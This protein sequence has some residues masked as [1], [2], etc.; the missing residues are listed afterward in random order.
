MEG[1]TGAGAVTSALDSSTLAEAEQG[2]KDFQRATV[3]Y[4]FRRLYTDDDWTRR[5][6]IADEVGL[7]KTLVARGVIARAV[8]RLWG[9]VDPINVVYVC[10]NRNIARQNVDRLNVTGEQGFDL[11]SR[12]TLL[13][14]EV[15]NLRTRSL[16]FVAL[17]PNTSFNLRSSMGK[18]EERALLY[19]L[20]DRAWGLDGAP[21]F[22]VLQGNVQD[23]REFRDYVR[24][25]PNK[26]DIDPALAG[27]F[28]KRLEA[29]EKTAR[30]EGKASLREEFRAVCERFP[31]AR[32]DP[33]RTPDEDRRDQREIIG[34]L[35]EELAATCVDALEPSLVVLDEFQRFKDLLTGD[36]EESFLAQKLFDYSRETD[37]RVL[38]LSATP[39]KMYTLSGSAGDH[40]HYEDFFETLR[41]L[42]DDEVESRQTAGLLKTYRRE[43][44]RLDEDSL[45]E[46]RRVKSAIEGTLRRVMVRTERLSSSQDRDGMLKEAE[47]GE[48]E[49]Q[50]SDVETYLA[51]QD[52]AEIFDHRDTVRYWKSAPYLL[53]FME[54]YKLK[55]AF[56]AALGSDET[57]EDLVEVISRRNGLVLPWDTVREYGEIESANPRLRS[58]A[59]D[60]LGSGAW[61]LLWLAPSLPYY[62]P[63]QPFSEERRRSFTKRL[64]FSAWR[65]VPKAIATLLSYGA[66]RRVVRSWEPDAKNTQERRRRH[67]RP[68]QFTKSEGRLRGMPVL[69]MLYPSTV[70][71]RTCDPLEIAQ[72]LT[73][74]TQG[75]PQTDEVKP[76]GG[77]I[78][79]E[80][81]SRIKTLLDPLLEVAP[82]EGASDESWYWAAPPLI[83]QLEN[84]GSTA[85]WWGRSSL[86][87]DWVEAEGDVESSGWAEHV[88]AAREMLHGQGTGLGP[89]PDDLADVLAHLGVAGPSVVALRALGRI[90]PDEF[91][92]TAVGIRDA[93][94]QIGWAFR[95][96]FNS[97]EAVALIRGLDEREPYW[98]RVLEYALAGNLQAVMDE[99]VHVL[100]DALGHVGEADYEVVESVA[101]RIQDALG[102]RTVSLRTDEISVD[103]D[104]GVIELHDDEY[105][106]AHFAHRFGDES[107]TEEQAGHRAE[108][109]RWAFNSPFWPFVLTTTSVGQ[110]GLDFH[111]YCHAVEHWNLPSNPVDLEQREGRVHRFKGHAVRRNLAEDFGSRLFAEEERDVDPWRSLF[112]YGEVARDE[113]QSELVP[114]WV[115][116]GQDG[117]GGAKIERHAPTLPLSRDSIRLS[118]LR[119]SL[120]VYRMV[121]GQPRQE[122]LLEFLLERFGQSQVEEWMDELCMD[123]SPPAA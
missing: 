91:D 42:Q 56:E 79:D 24:S 23:W 14:I 1:K 51:L 46:V 121:F 100:K 38:L 69:G 54:G 17:T 107:G 11:A 4:V 97:P 28:V 92:Q 78:L 111:T 64:V 39:Y 94:A 88:E 93:S 101:D 52:L 32:Q 29:N 30:E 31:R 116:P 62:R 40:D 37:V 81:R 102:L 98:R 90:L 76:T 67:H 63:S 5:F 22:N 123:L 57:P 59:E 96:L 72:R 20:L 65:V 87:K 55:R 15:S 19:H 71:A 53:T 112:R 106:R 120:A 105:M 7:G 13:P 66:E 70:L 103:G 108:Q 75:E 77:A 60:I 6:L 115:Y 21:P 26:H 33:Y 45:S 3:D 61:R 48:L 47:A 41:F 25:F 18:R 73:A 2:L 35:R 34:E 85:K 74:E 58:V 68:L 99:Y 16:N 118:D 110:E 104:A 89:P 84:P 82:R 43:L 109:V 113:G 27:S 50:L 83:D 12:L 119:G 36:D 80:A 122:D 114:F 49:L 8:R 86:A 44:F 10:S 9:E 117:E 95:S